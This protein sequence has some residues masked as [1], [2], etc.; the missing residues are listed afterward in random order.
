MTRRTGI[1]QLRVNETD[2][3]NFKAVAHQLDRDE[4]SAIRIVMAKVAAE[5]AQTPTKQ[6]EEHAEQMDRAA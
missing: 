1:F 5:L 3:I 4:S 2:R 6:D